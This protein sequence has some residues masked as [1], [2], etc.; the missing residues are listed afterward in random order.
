MF[1]WALHSLRKQVAAEVRRQKATNPALVRARHSRSFRAIQW[2]LAIDSFWRWIVFYSVLALIVGLVD[3]IA[4]QF[5][6]TLRCPTASALLLLTDHDAHLLFEIGGYLIGAQVGVL[7]TLSIAVSLV[8]LIGQNG[9][10]DA[11]V[12]VYYYE[13]LT[14]PL[15]ASSVA[16]L[17]VLCIQLVWPIDFLAR[18]L[19]FASASLAAPAVLTGVHLL[20]LILNLAAFAHFALTSLSFGQPEAR[21]ASRRRYTAAHVIPEQLREQLSQAYYFNLPQSLALPIEDGGTS[22]WFRSWT[23][24]MPIT[25]V[26]RS[27]RTPHKL[28]DVFQTP[29]GWAMRSWMRRA[30]GANLRDAKHSLLAFTVGFG[31]TVEG[32][33]IICRRRGTVPFNRFE[34]I[35]IH[36]SFRFRRVH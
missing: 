22:V 20:W 26:S 25:E 36:V 29:L 18:R 7:A 23:L 3:G 32:T 33:T 34:R 13:S 21:A 19:D 24:Q 30:N 6:L 1:D 12:Q 4:A 10:A 28:V 27:F 9:N 17:A 2:I 31:Q 35:L 16:L 11:D 5:C 14:L 15:V 8:T